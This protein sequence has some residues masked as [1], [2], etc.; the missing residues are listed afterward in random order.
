MGKNTKKYLPLSF[1]GGWRLWIRPV[2]LYSKWTKWVAHTSH[3]VSVYFIWRLVHPIAL[4]LT[5]LLSNLTFFAQRS[6][7][8]P[9]WLTYKINLVF[10]YLP[11]WDYHFWYRFWPWSHVSLKISILSANAR[12]YLIYE[13]L[14]LCGKY[15]NNS[16]VP[17]L[18]YACTKQCESLSLECFANCPS[19]D[20]A[21][22]R[23]CLR[24][25]SECIQGKT[26]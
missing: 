17:D 3:F 23:N 14:N 4:H 10:H 25:N 7:E 13:G 26:K 22:W 6:W 2:S 24:E 16:R 8:F 19:D 18:N 20:T 5:R 1:L 21:C 11:K 12:E 9:K 15:Q